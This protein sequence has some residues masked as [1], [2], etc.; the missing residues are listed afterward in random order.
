MVS[1]SPDNYSLQ[2]VIILFTFYFLI[3]IF[4]LLIG[5]LR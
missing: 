4:H 3:F 5:F 2:M 1:I